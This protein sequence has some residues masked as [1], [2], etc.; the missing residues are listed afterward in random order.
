M[1]RDKREAEMARIANQNVAY[2]EMHS[3][4]ENP[5]LTLLMLFRYTWRQDLGKV[6]SERLHPAVEGNRS[7][8]PQSN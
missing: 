4:K 5:H 7:R 1:C 3:M 6:S 2:L 8:H